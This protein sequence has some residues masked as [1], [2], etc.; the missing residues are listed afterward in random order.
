MALINHT[1][2]IW[3]ND[4]VVTSKSDQTWHFVFYDSVP[5]ISYWRFFFSVSWLLV[6]SSLI[7]T[8]GAVGRARVN[9][10]LLVRIRFHFSDLRP[11]QIAP[12][13][14]LCESITICIPPRSWLWF[15]LCWV[16]IFTLLLLWGWGVFLG[17]ASCSRFPFY[18]GVFISFHLH[19]IFWFIISCVLSPSFCVSV[20]NWLLLSFLK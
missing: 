13:V 18:C 14:S 7:P 3:I 16:F 8:N 15:N 6:F 20:F 9:W 1:K 5:I 4:K 10:Q 19:H 17:K 12:F 2:W 11:H